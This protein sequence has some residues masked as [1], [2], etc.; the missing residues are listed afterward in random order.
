MV[1]GGEEA[2]RCWRN[3]KARHNDRDE[4]YVVT[5]FLQYPVKQVCSFLL[6]KGN[7]TDPKTFKG[8]I[9]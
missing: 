9:P 4:D 5:P 1:L 8:R 6:K 7:I 2:A 3:V